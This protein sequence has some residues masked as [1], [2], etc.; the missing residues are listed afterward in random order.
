MTDRVTFG[1]GL[2]DTSRYYNSR[3]EQS[4]ARIAQLE[5]ELRYAQESQDRLV[6]ALKA[7]K[8]RNGE[9]TN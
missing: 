6:D 4:E 2:D 8:E 7:C 9:P 3:L 1:N 5:Q